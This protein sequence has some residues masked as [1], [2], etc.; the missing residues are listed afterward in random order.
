MRSSPGGRPDLRRSDEG[1]ATSRS[2]G[3][4]RTSNGVCSPASSCVPTTPIAA[5]SYQWFGLA[6][7]MTDVNGRPVGA[8]VISNAAWKSIRDPAA[9]RT[10]APR[11]TP[12]GGRSADPRARC[13]GDRRDEDHGLIRYDVPPDAVGRVAAIGKAGYRMIVGKR[14][15]PRRS[16]RSRSCATP[17]REP[18]VELTWKST[19]QPVA[20]DHHRRS[21]LARRRL[22]DGRALALRR[23]CRRSSGAAAVLSVGIPARP[24]TSRT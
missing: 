2:D 4:R 7:H 11:R 18:G 12:A 21:G 13:R 1:W 10:S 5:L 20:G 3:R 15:R 23:C 16:P 9:R 17:S 14:C 24:G 8:L 19:W 6:N 22:P